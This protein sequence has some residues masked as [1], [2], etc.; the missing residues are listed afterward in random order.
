MVLAT[1]K[2]LF[3]NLVSPLITPPLH[4]IL[5]DTCVDYLKDFGID[6]IWLSP[7]YKSPMDDWGQY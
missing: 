5:F 2:A 4:W 3:L 1:S 6:V 7:T